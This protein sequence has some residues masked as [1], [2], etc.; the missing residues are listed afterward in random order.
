[1]MRCK[2]LTFAASCR[3]RASRSAWSLG[4]LMLLGAT[5]VAQSPPATLQVA[6]PPDPAA[7]AP[8]RAAPA[9]APQVARGVVYHDSNANGTRDGDEPGLPGVAVSNGRQVVVTDGSG[10]YQLPITG[11]CILFVI[12]PR[13]WMVP[14]GADQ[15][16]QFYTIHKPAGS[17]AQTFPGVPP[18][19]PLPASVDFGLR[20]QTEPQQLRVVMFGDTQPRNLQE[21]DYMLKDVIAQVADSDAHGASLGVTLGDI[22]FDDLN[23]MPAVNAAVSLI[24]LPWFNVL[25]NHD[26][27]Y[28]SPDDVYS[29]ETFQSIYGPPYYAFDWGSAHFIVLDNVVW[30]GPSDEFP[31]GRYYAGLGERQL[32]FVRNDLAL[33]PKDRLVVLLMHIPLPAIEERQQLYDLLADFPHTLSFSAH[34]HNTQHR[35]IDAAQGWRQDQPHHH[36]VHATVCGSWWS[37]EPDEFGIPHAMMSDGGPNGY[38]ILDIDGQDF[39][40]EFYPARRPADHQMSI[41]L[42]DAL[43][44]DEVGDAQVVVNVFQGS[45]ESQ[46]RMRIVP[47]GPWQELERYE[48]TDP[49]I[50]QLKELEADGKLRG[51]PLPKPAVTDHLWRGNLPAGLAP[52]T[53]GIAVETV[54]R[55]GQ[56]F[57]QTK[58]LRVVSRP[59]R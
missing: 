35:F 9:A 27:N 25:G 15:L 10:G 41:W 50:E 18:T 4:W 17:P 39:R 59:K 1:M 29:T 55:F 7:V 12:K 2:S 57:E 32:E 48:G 42:P 44:E 11:D 40:L 6:P 46:V 49:A 16:P 13:G 36:V 56:R 28:D 22:V 34:T 54:D 33:V 24:G 43:A 21:I 53:Y 52:G 14:L 51:R 3:H 58:P 20:P 19:G 26:M 38:S 45:V 31:R 23:L 37:G 8:A 30:E 47:D 5:V